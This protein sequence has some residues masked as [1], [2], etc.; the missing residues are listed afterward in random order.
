ML[1]RK[2]P[3]IFFWVSLSLLFVLSGFHILARSSAKLPSELIIS[4]FMAVNQTVLMD[5]DGASSDWIEIYNRSLQPVN[6]S[7]WTLTDDVTQP[8]KWMFPDVTLGSKEYLVVF[9]SGKNRKSV[10]PGTF[11]HTNFR[12]SKNTQFLALHNVLER[13]YMDIIKPQSLE[14]FEDISY[15]RRGDEL[16][17]G[18]FSVPSPGRANNES[19]VSENV[20][21]PTTLGVNVSLPVEDQF[22]HSFSPVSDTDA[23]GLQTMILDGKL[24]ITEI[25][26]HPIGGSEYEF[27]ELQNVGNQ[28]VNLSGAYFEGIT[29][30][31]ADNLVPLAPGQF[32][33][34]V[35]NPTAFAERYPGVTISQVYSGNL[36]NKG[37]RITLR[38][39]FGQIL[40][41][42]T[43][44]DENEWPISPDGL[45]DSLVLIHV[46]GD[47]N[48]PGNW[49][50][51]IELN[52]SPGTGHHFIAAK[53]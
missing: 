4:E 6:L 41:S 32:I 7:G 2:K 50:A 20:V 15:G 14:Q 9:A 52:G 29:L 33:V 12:L 51:S 26:Y 16:Q 31:F 36:S 3:R 8:N 48:D 17:A 30:T 5:E 45:G 42:V 27:I 11:L 21:S 40:T 22:S 43:Y 10:E 24:R 25:M 35:R 44:D 19:F 49:R 37:E 46:D 13:R 28:P 1:T 18:Y 39:T 34:L 23:G 38:N 47:P 53:P